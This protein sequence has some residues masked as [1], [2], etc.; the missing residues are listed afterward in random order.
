MVSMKIE[1]E[2]TSNSPNLEDILQLTFAL[3]KKAELEGETT[4]QIKLLPMLTRI[5]LYLHKR[6]HKGDNYMTSREAIE[7]MSQEECNQMT[8]SLNALLERQEQVD[9]GADSYNN[10]CEEPLNIHQNTHQPSGLA[11]ENQQYTGCQKTI[12]KPQ[13]PYERRENKASERCKNKILPNY[14]AKHGVNLDDKA[15]PT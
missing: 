15:I 6:K 14:G 12:A 2:Y 1:K 4:T 10:D 7:S 8:K 11:C 13:Q 5:A 9:G 3:Y